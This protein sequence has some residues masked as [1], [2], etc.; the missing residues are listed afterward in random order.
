MK[1]SL[2]GDVKV[3]IG[4]E[5]DTQPLEGRSSSKQQQPTNANN[6]TVADT[7]SIETTPVGLN[8]MTEAL[9]R[10]AGFTAEVALV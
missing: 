5:R 9:N 2:L 4:T 6:T 8:E 3:S 10:L 7:P 1:E